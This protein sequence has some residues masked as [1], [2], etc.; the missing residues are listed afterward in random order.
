MLASL[1]RGE[2]KPDHLWVYPTYLCQPCFGG[3][4]TQRTLAMQLRPM[5][6]IFRWGTQE[7]EEHETGEHLEKDVLR[8]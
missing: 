7:W 3:P 4:V 2:G 8:L 5:S 6:W 1:L